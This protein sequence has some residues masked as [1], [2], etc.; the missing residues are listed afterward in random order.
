MNN[1]ER[2]SHLVN[3]TRKFTDK[4]ALF[5]SSVNKAE[6]NDIDVLIFADQEHVGSIRKILS[7]NKQLHP[8]YIEKQ[9][10]SYSGIKDITEE[11]LP[12]NQK[13]IH[14]SFVPKSKKEYEGTALWAKNN[15]SLKF[16]TNQ[17]S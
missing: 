2:L 5:G 1:N 16:L 14:V 17:S 15:N 12:S 9:I 6:F 13:T 10:C 7:K 11:D 8:I 4:V 3:A